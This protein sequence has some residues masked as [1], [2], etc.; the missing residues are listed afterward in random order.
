MDF[1]V[2]CFSAGRQ[3]LLLSCRIRSCLL[4]R[5]LLE[6]KD[7]MLLRSPSHPL[8]MRRDSNLKLLV[9]NLDRLI[10]V[11]SIFRSSGLVG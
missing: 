7:G 11:P 6:L 9:G 5:K 10:Y 3:Y 1:D 8:A 2:G 4:T